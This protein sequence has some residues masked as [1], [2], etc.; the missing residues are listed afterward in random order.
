MTTELPPNSLISQEKGP[1]HL[2]ER[3]M[4]RYN[5]KEFLP[6]NV[7]LVIYS[8]LDLLTLS[9]KICGL[10]QKERQKVSSSE[11]IDQPLSMDIQLR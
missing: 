3:K 9:N 11:L 5:D 1:K 7:R 6:R 4:K 8:F 10:S 2:I